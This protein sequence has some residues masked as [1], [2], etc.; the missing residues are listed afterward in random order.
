MIMTIFMS[1]AYLL[2]KQIRS[3]IENVIGNRNDYMYFNCQVNFT[4]VLLQL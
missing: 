3:V 4:L 1:D 2:I